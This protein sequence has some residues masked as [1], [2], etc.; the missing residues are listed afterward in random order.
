MEQQIADTLSQIGS[1]SREFADKAAKGEDLRKI[2]YS[3]YVSTWIDRLIDFGIRV[4]I[5]I[6]LAYIGIFLTRKIVKLFRRSL[7]RRNADPAVISFLSS[8]INTL[9]LLIVIII[10]VNVLGFQAVSFAA[11]LAGAGVAIGAA[12]SGQLQNLAAGMVILFTRPFHVGDWIV[13]KEGEGEVDS[14]AIFFTTLKTVDNS[15]IYIPNAVLMSA[16]VTN[17]SEMK[18]RRCQWVVGVEYDTDINLVRAALNELIQADKRVLDTPEPLIV[19][20]EMGSSSVNV[21][22]R[23]WCEN[24]DYWALY[25]DM[26]K[27]IYDLFNERGIPFAFNTMRIISDKEQSAPERPAA[28]DNERNA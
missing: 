1:L 11:L 19:L 20:R 26:N 24:S 5:A 28:N 4:L 18:L 27:R 12:L 16:S 6:V 14:V 8:L 3:G 25:W 17:R 9:C 21:M 10:A 7:A 2:D 15:K 23:A 22:L 13:S